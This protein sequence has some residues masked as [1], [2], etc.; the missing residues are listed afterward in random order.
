L[1]VDKN[2]ALDLNIIGLFQIKN[3]CA[4]CYVVL[5]AV[6]PARI[7]T[8][9]GVTKVVTVAVCCVLSRYINQL[10]LNITKTSVIKFTPKTTARVLLDIYY[11]DNVID[12][13]KSTKFLGMHIDKHMNWKN[14][15][16][17]IL[18]KLS[19]ACFGFGA[20]LCVQFN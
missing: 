7:E 18:P 16:E 2:F 13:V 9:Q 6:C 20:V 17:Q 4:I 19:A 8:S 15:L 5:V 10:V 14:H 1:R 12:K 3:I 11:K